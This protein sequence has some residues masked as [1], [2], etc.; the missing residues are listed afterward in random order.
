[1]SFCCCLHIKYTKNMCGLATLCYYFFSFC[2]IEASK[3]DHSASY[4]VDWW[5]LLE[6]VLVPAAKTLHLGAFK[7]GGTLTE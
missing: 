6:A 2:I 1:M 3:V 4:V 7:S 5:W